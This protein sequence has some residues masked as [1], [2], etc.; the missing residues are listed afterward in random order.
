MMRWR[1]IYKNLETLTAH[2]NTPIEHVYTNDPFKKITSKK[3]ESSNLRLFL[4]F[5]SYFNNSTIFIYKFL[6]YF[7]QIL[8]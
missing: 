5:F 1:M 4:F 6:T 7:L 8:F 2:P 3:S